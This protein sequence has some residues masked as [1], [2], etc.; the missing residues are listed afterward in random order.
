MNPAKKS[1]D[2]IQNA[3]EFY[4]PWMEPDWA[5]TP[6]IASA[7]PPPTLKSRSAFKFHSDYSR[8]VHSRNSNAST[9]IE[10]YS[11]WKPV[12]FE[13]FFRW[14][15]NGKMDDIHLVKKILFDD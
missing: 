9:T 13:K 10:K 1:R 15:M 5:P 4:E 2:L 8:Q 12:D 11:N 7:T 14:V 3:K 6:S